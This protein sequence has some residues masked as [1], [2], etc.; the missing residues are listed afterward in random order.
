MKQVLGFTPR[1]KYPK[2]VPTG[3]S[4]RTDESNLTIRCVKISEN[5]MSLNRSIATLSPFSVRSQIPSQL[6]IGAVSK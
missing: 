2:I 3:I 4:L 1:V 6:S 5:R